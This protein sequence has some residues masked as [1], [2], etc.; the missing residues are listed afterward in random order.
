MS[1]EYH[2]IAT[3][4][5]TRLQRQIGWQTAKGLPASSGMVDVITNGGEF[6]FVAGTI[7]QANIIGSGE[8]GAG[9]DAAY[10][11]GPVTVNLGDVDIASAG[12]LMVEASVLQRYDTTNP[13]GAHFRHRLGATK[14]TAV[15]PGM[16]WVD[17]PDTG[18]RPRFADVLASQFVYDLK[19]KANASMGATLVHGGWDLFGAV[20]QSTG[21]GVTD[22]GLPTFGNTWE[23]NRVAD[24]VDRIIQVKVISVSPFTVKVKVG[25]STTFD[26]LAITAV[27]SKRCFLF[28]TTADGAHVPIGGFGEQIWMRCDDMSAWEV[29]DVFTVQKRRARATPSYPPQVLVP[30]THCRFYV[31]G[32]EFYADQGLTLTVA[33]GN[34]EILTAAAAGPQPIGTLVSG[35]TS[36]IFS[37][38]KRLTNL[39][40]YIAA[41]NRYKTT[42][43][44]EAKSNALIGATTQNYMRAYVAPQ[45]RYVGVKPFSPGVGAGGPPQESYTLIAEIPDSTLSYRGMDFTGAFE[46]VWDGDIISVG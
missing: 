3:G 20:T 7:E 27:E 31:G 33:R 9:L 32:D 43:I 41:M 4:D 13:S 42:V 12:Q 44:L 45:C 26:G 17:D 46:S 15:P 35:F 39:D 38:S 21:T 6:S 10:E 14:G 28:G 18:V 34:A 16:S 2:D 11:V 37:V 40:A 30:E 5:P 1:Q 29:N 22:A 24:S 23:G 8:R 25:A 19:S 36:F